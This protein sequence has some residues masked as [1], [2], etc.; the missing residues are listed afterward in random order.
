MSSHAAAA[1]AC[2]LLQI[3][4]SHHIALLECFQDQGAHYLP[5]DPVTK[6]LFFQQVLTTCYSQAPG[7]SSDVENPMPLPLKGLIL[8]PEGRRLGAER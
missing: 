2:S 8:P 6:V 5:G 3:P 7:E 4:P 1:Q